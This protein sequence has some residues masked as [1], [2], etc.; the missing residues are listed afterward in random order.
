MLFIFPFSIRQLTSLL[1]GHPT[2][3]YSLSDD[4]WNMSDNPL[5]VTKCCWVGITIVV[6]RSDLVELHV[7]AHTHKNPSKEADC[8]GQVDEVTFLFFPIIM[9]N[10]FQGLSPH[11]WYALVHISTLQICVD[12]IS[13]WKYFRWVD[14]VMCREKTDHQIFEYPDA[15]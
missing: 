11:E 5:N 6:S 13:T 4:G 15:C 9:V 12:S 3:I 7:E 8:L 10:L 1:I 14:A 2:K